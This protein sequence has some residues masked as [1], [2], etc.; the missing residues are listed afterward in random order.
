MPDEPTLATKLQAKARGMQARRQVQEK[1]VANATTKV[2]NVTISANQFS[3]Q[4][5]ELAGTLQQQAALVHER[6]VCEMR[7]AKALQ[8]AV[9]LRTKSAM[10]QQLE[11]KQ[12]GRAIS[13]MQLAVR[14]KR[15]MKEAT[16]ARAEAEDASK[17]AAEAKAALARDRLAY[18]REREESGRREAERDERYQD[19]KAALE[20]Q[21]RELRDRE[22]G[23]AAEITRDEES[24]AA[25][26]RA[27]AEGRVAEVERSHRAEVA[28]LEGTVANAEAALEM[29]QRV[30]D[31]EV[32]TAR[33]ELEVAKRQV[34]EEAARAARAEARAAE[35]TTGSAATWASAESEGASLRMEVSRLNAMLSDAEADWS[36]RLSAKGA[37]FDAYKAQAESQARSRE[38]MLR[39]Q[40]TEANAVAQS[41]AD[42]HSRELAT[43]RRAASESS[44]EAA[45]RHQR[46]T[47]TLRAQAQAAQTSEQKAAHV[48]VSAAASREGVLRREYEQQLQTLRQEVEAARGELARRDE[49]HCSQVADISE[50]AAT[51]RD[52]T[53][54]RIESLRQQLEAV[55]TSCRQLHVSEDQLR[56]QLDASNAELA[57]VSSRCMAQDR[58]IEGMQQGAATETSRLSNELEVERSKAW[59]VQAEAAAE[60]HHR[61]ALLSQELEAAKAATAP[62]QLLVDSLKREVEEKHNHYHREK[63][64][65]ITAAAHT[66]QLRQ[67]VNEALM[68]QAGEHSGALRAA[69]EKNAQLEQAVASLQRRIEMQERSMQALNGEVEGERRQ[70]LELLTAFR[71]LGVRR[72]YMEQYHGRGDV[73]SGGGSCGRV[74]YGGERY[75]DGGYG[76]HSLISPSAHRTSASRSDM[77][78]ASP[79]P[80]IP[81]LPPPLNLQAINEHQAAV[82]AMCPPS[83]ATIAQ[84]AVV[85]AREAGRALPPNFFGEL[86]PDLLSPQ[87]YASFPQSARGEAQAL[88]QAQA[89]AALHAQQQQR[90]GATPALGTSHPC[91]SV[92][93]TTFCGPPNLMDAAAAVRLNQARHSATASPALAD[94]PGLSPGLMPRPHGPPFSPASLGASSHGAGAVVAAMLP[95]N[96]HH[97]ISPRHP[98]SPHHTTPLASPD[99]H[100]PQP[101]S[102]RLSPFGRASRNAEEAELK[103]EVA[104]L[105][106]GGVGRSESSLRASPPAI[107]GTSS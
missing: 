99:V 34:A 17:E 69:Q 80:R 93:G 51:H 95:T 48:A 56:Q 44:A 100:L 15:L 35:V 107:W 87:F 104:E 16:A 25:A 103:A 33:R 40:L 45:T 39:Q 32:Q 60:F 73:G 9:R 47:E 57:R 24:T 64:A 92:P 30:K 65:S 6:G 82:D 90:V 72:S 83:M 23:T 91:T 43:A 59:A 54:V 12:R 106:T 42:R 55:T 97:A 4:T 74:E 3:S 14:L 28:V 88:L 96:R 94:S 26:T 18:E 7:A 2:V 1:L 102:Y 20:D 61:E 21:S 98:N 49:R 41:Q 70:K 52:E 38:S 66:A 63:E 53:A 22:V 36:Q 11:L 84:H 86:S 19:E 79:S 81:P 101:T 29:A 62:L 76:G 37:E 13:G 78:A 10:V 71:E 5:A 31:D 46:E 105:A 27:M 75:G 50:K 89:Q 67:A 58:Q 85:E 68:Q 77:L 8:M